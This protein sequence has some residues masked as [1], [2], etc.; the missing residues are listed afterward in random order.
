MAPATVEQ[1]SNH[2]LRRSI[3]GWAI[4]EDFNVDFSS[5]ECKLKSDSDLSGTGVGCVLLELQTFQILT[6]S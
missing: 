3:Q 6:R 1:Y 5:P 2:H 4:P